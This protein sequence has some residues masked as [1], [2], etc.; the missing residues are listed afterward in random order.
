MFASP[1]GPSPRDY[2]NPAHVRNSMGQFEFL[3]QKNKR[4]NFSKKDEYLRAAAHMILTGQDLD[5]DRMKR[6]IAAVSV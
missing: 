3:K 6:S 4:R 2:D 1:N 5:I